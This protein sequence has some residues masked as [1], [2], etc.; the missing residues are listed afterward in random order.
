M[1]ELIKHKK[2]ISDHLEKCL[3]NPDKFQYSSRTAKLLLDLGFIKC[4]FYEENLQIGKF[5]CVFH[6]ITEAG[7]NFYNEYNRLVDQKE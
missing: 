1:S 3:N 7:R 5:T 2:R 4:V 6:E